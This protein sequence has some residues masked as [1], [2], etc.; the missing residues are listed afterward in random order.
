MIESRLQKQW[1]LTITELEDARSII[2]PAAKTKEEVARHLEEYEDFLEHEMGSVTNAYQSHSHL[3][4]TLLGAPPI[5]IN[6]TDDHNPELWWRL[7]D[8]C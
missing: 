8:V 5:T 6:S 4:P 3:S 7:S 1:K 2:P